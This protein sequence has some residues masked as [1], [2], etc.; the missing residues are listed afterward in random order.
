M[1][2][3]RI[4]SRILLI[5]G[6]K[7]MIDIDLA[8]LY[9]VPTKRLNEQVKRN[10][11]RFP[12]DFMFQLTATEKQEVV[13][14]CDHLAKLKFSKSLPYAFT[15]HGA[16]Q[17]ANVL[18]SPQAIETGVYVVRVFVHLRELVTSNKE[19]ALRL[20]ELENKTDLMS[21]KQ[22]AFEHNTRVQLKQI[23][24]TLRELMTPPPTVPKRPIGFV[25]P[26]DR[27]AKGKK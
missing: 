14:N 4:E 24:D 5:R 10:Q 13:A 2:L 19:L 21:L 11:E 18:A 9:G 12:A 20:D 6:Q 15:E 17:A 25:T 7:V 3:A 27:P 8:E 1:P 23:I 16:I 22:D 26:D